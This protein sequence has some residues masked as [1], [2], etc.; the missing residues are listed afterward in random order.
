MKS[1]TAVGQTH[2][3]LDELFFLCIHMIDFIQLVQMLGK[4]ENLVCIHI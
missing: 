4:E 2:H 1:T 3:C